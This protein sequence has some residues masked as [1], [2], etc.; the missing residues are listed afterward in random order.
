RT[1]TLKK[2]V[3]VPVGVQ[4]PMNDN[5]PVSAL[6]DSSAIGTFINASWAQQKQ[7]KLLPLRGPIPVLNDNGTRNRD[8]DI[9][10]GVALFVKITHHAEKL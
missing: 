2:E 1:T 3:R 8:G 7:I 6:L 5:I 9:M 10:H 4:G